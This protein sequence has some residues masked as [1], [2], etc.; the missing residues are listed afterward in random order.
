VLRAATEAIMVAV[1]GLLEELRGEQAPAEPYDLRQ[2]LAQQRRK[3]AEEG[4][5]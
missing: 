1:T 4:T 5:K 3:A 2:V